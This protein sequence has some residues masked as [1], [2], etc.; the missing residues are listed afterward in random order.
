MIERPDI[1]ATAMAKVSAKV[2]P[3][4]IRALKEDFARLITRVEDIGLE[5]PGG[6]RE[7]AIAVTHLQTAS[8]FAVHALSAKAPP[9]F[10]EDDTLEA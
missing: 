8:M 3:P 7:A 2:G 5:T 1:S 9:L 4:Y 6:A 10:V